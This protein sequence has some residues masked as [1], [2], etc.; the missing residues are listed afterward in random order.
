MIKQLDRRDRAGEMIVEI[1]GK[2]FHVKFD[3]TGREISLGERLVINF[4]A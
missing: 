4:S 1:T 3:N 2:C